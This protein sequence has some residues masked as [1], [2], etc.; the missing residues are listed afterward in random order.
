MKL[1][2]IAIIAVVLIVLVAVI[3]IP[4]IDDDTKG[5]DTVEKEVRIPALDAERPAMTEKAT[6]AMG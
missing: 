1:P 3:A 5:E 2:I 6:F 4:F